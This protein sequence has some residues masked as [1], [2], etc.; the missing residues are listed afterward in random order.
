MATEGNI[1]GLAAGEDWDIIRDITSVPPGIN[2]NTAKLVV[3]D[4]WATPDNQAVI[5]VNITPVYQSN[6]G[7]ISVANGLWTLRF[8]ATK[9]ATA[10]L[11]IGHP[12]V[13]RMSYTTDT[14]LTKVPERG[15]IITQ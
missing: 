2:I 3:K 15:I 12:Y 4:D 14:G 5:T 10:A 1:T 13:F 7:G 11:T 6:V 8:Q 9:V